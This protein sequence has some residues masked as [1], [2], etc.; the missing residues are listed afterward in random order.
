MTDAERLASK[1]LSA[2]PLDHTQA[3]C[4]GSKSGITGR[5]FPMCLTCGRYTLRPGAPVKGRV[6]L[7]RG[8]ADCEHWMPNHAAEVAPIGMGETSLDQQGV[9]TSSEAG[10]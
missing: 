9:N 1:G 7:L 5:D 10:A 2:V 8:E 6:F 4:N 3:K